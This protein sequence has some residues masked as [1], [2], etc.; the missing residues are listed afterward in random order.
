M[1]DF[2][3]LGLAP[4]LPRL[5]T[6]AHGSRNPA[7][8]VLARQITNG[9]ARRLGVPTVTS[10]VELCEPTFA[11]VMEASAEP[12]VVVPLLL[13]TGYHVRQDLPAA[14]AA[15]DAPTWLA[16]PLG[17][18]PLL[19]EVMCLRLQATGARPGDPVVLLAAGSNDPDAA[20]DLECAA[21]LLRAR[22]GGAPVRVA[23][24][25]GAGPRIADVVAEARDEGRVAVAPYL[26]APGHFATRAR[27]LAIGSG[28]TWVSDVIGNHPLVGELVVRRYRA[29]VQQMV[30]AAA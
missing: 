18:H 17:P 27:T 19:A 24:M 6:V 29:M 7:G 16:R 5:V 21:Q 30:R 11:S 25:S 28:A 10:Y 14:I 13:S 3:E 2:R 26:L 23:T 8:N 4:G 22:W 9:V 12:T 20:T 15:T 1:G